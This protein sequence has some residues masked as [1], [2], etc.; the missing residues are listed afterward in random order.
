[1][2]VSTSTQQPPVARR[3]NQPWQ[4]RAFALI[5]ENT[6]VNTSEMPGVFFSYSEFVHM[7]LLTHTIPHC[8]KEK[9]EDRLTFKFRVDNKM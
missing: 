6:P 8:S 9:L 7:P 5:L 3:D 1:M 2:L 4:G